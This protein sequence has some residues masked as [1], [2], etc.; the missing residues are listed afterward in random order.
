VVE[1]EQGEVRWA[2]L[3]DPVG[4]EPGYRR[5][6]VI[7]Q[8]NAL[9]RSRISTVVC[10]PLTSNLAWAEALGN[11]LIPAR[12]SGL[13]RDSVANGSQILAIDRMFLGERTGRISPR[14]LSQ[15]LNGIDIV[16]GR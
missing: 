7:V 5:P 10:V 11:T 8:G 9:N 13:P 16:L 1:I 4:S 15:V 2:E 3:A 12:V 6:V 14:Y